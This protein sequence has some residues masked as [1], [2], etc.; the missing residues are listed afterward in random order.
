MQVL[1]LVLMLVLLPVMRLQNE[2]GHSFAAGWDNYLGPLDGWLA[3][4]RGLRMNCHL[5]VVSPRAWLLACTRN[6]YSKHPY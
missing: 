2:M 6:L 1:L 4:Q 3:I 5:R